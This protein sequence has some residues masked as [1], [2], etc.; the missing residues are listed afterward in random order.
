[1]RRV[2]LSAGGAL[3]AKGAGALFTL[4]AGVLVARLFGVEVA[5][6]FFLAVAVATPFAVM[7]RLGLEN[8]LLRDT[9]A[10]LADAR[11]AQ[12]APQYVRIL[13]A[14]GT[15]ATLAATLLVV[16][17]WPLA[18]W[19]FD[20]P[21]L[22]VWL[23]S[24]AAALFAIAL[25]NIHVA[26]LKGRHLPVWAQ[27]AESA[28][29]PALFVAGILVVAWL[30]QPLLLP[31][32]WVAAWW[33]AMLLAFVLAVRGLFPMRLEKPDWRPLVRAGRPFLAVAFFN[34]LLTWL[35]IIWLGVFSAQIDV[36]QFGAAV[37]VAM[38]VSVVLIAINTALSARIAA[39][40]QR[41]DRALVRR[42]YMRAQQVSMVTAL[43]VVSVLAFF[44][45]EIMGL[46]GEAFVSAAGLLGILL[47]GQV[48]GAA[49]G[50]VGQLLAMTG[51]ERKL[52]RAFAVSASI[53]VVLG[54]P[55]A[56][57]GGAVGMA[58]LVAG[59]AT[60]LSLLALYYSRSLWRAA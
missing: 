41:G 31:W 36:A 23:L 8:V 7:S 57:W 20:N 2:I 52:R 42:L 3:A 6:N 25:L 12:I 5:G 17:A 22:T 4:L 34:Q 11:S 13:G 44:A 47:L 54:A 53:Q 38:A 1:M 28:L 32:V 30:A 26:L 50:P 35:P 18:H 29:Y 39:A 51:H 15:A 24:G 48:V 49:S 55:V 14:T 45:S 27:T 21:T 58:C 40:W 19:I 59:A 46:Y 56:W 37:R 43:V 60:M 9:A 10:A 16:L 33:A